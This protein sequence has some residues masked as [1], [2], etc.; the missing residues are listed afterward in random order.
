MRHG[1]SGI[2]TT[3]PAQVTIAGTTMLP[4]PRTTLASELKIHTRTAPAKTTLE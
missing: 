4:V 2:S 1:D 3:T